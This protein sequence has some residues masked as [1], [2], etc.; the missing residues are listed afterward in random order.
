MFQQEALTNGRTFGPLKLRGIEL[1]HTNGG[2]IVT[3]IQKL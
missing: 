2:I 3:Q 1:P